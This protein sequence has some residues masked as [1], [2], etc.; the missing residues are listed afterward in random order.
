MRS[1]MIVKFAGEAP[2]VTVPRRLMRAER[3]RFSIARRVVTDGPFA[4]TK[5]MA[6][7]Y[8]AEQGDDDVRNSENR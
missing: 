7:A 3:G 6:G 8:R 2:V 4:E 1:M 5:E